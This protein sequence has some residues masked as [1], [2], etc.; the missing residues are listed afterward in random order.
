[1]F[2][3]TTSKKLNEKITIHYIIQVSTLLLTKNY[4]AFYHYET[5]LILLRTESNH[6]YYLMSYHF[7]K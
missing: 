5:L 4:K 3:Q 7:I 2:L 1:M 6:R